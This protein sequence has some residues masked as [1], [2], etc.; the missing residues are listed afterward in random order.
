M[1]SGRNERRLLALDYH[2]SVPPA[3]VAHMERLGRRL[4]LPLD[5]LELLGQEASVCQG[6]IEACGAGREREF[7]DLLDRDD[8]EQRRRSPVVAQALVTLVVPTRPVAR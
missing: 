7:L 5:T 6:F 2:P 3:L 1:D 8:L 4:G